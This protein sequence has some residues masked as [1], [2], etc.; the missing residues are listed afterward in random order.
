M[1]GQPGVTAATA[2]AAFPPLKATTLALASACFLLGALIALL[3]LATPPWMDEFNTYVTT[4]HG[5]SLAQFFE[6]SLRGQ[7]PLGFEGP[8]FLA[9]A[10]GV[11]DIVLL[12]LYNL[13][14]VALALFAV[15]LAHR[16]ASIT[17]AQAA[18]IIALYV[19]SFGFLSY[20]G[21][22]RPYFLVFSASIAVA[23][24]W[25]MIFIEGWRKPLWLWCGA[26]AIF[27]NLH[28]F[29][30]IFGGLLTAALIVQTLVRRDVR[31]AVAIGVVSA[32][33]ASPAIVLGALQSTSTIGSGTLYY[34]IPG[35]GSGMDAIV[36]ATGAAIAL[37]VPVGLCALW[38]AGRAV[39]R[40]E[41]LD[42]LA[43]LGVVLLF[44]AIMLGAHLYKPL[45]YDRY[46]FAAAGGIMVAA[47][48]LSTGTDW[49]RFLAP[50]ICAYALLVQGW[51]LLFAPRL[52]GWEPSAEFVADFVDKCA[53][54]KVYT[55]PYARVSNGP[56]W[57]TPLN[58]TEI[59]ARRFGYHYYAAR[60]HFE[61]QELSP[62]ASVGP[63]GNC[64]S[65]IWIEHFW[66]TSPPEALLFNLRIHNIGPAYFAQIG[67]GVVVTVGPKP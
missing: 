14:G 28:Y 56:I 50:V 52:D 35:L 10:L 45:L 32:F 54:T 11:T 21:S 58:P 49:R 25:R 65:V 18:V 16:K 67:S 22:L 39:W 5:H 1:S 36:H 53:T 13:A 42:A 47:A 59:D 48:V 46:L 17:L 62:G 15:W 43:L 27:A 31:G 60:H 8:I 40:R 61:T 3:D 29:A 51:A 26:L 24:A 44:F 12:R 57:T 6:F 7:H 2:A 64:L 23:L 66:P 30:T 19:S 20:F 55:V 33:A 38:G 41:N 4:M 9:Q 37:N 63:S 34:F